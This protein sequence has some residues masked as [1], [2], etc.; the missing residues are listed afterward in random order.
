MCSIVEQMC[1]RFIEG[2]AGYDERCNGSTD[3]GKRTKAVRKHDDNNKSKK[4]RPND[5]LGLNKMLTAYDNHILINPSYYDSLHMNNAA[6]FL[7]PR[8]RATSLLKDV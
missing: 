8:L 4:M 5:R 3:V 1:W 2:V 7:C 6:G